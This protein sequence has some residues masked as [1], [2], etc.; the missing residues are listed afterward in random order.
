[1]ATIKELFAKEKRD[2][3]SIRR[4]LKNMGLNE[5]L[6]DVS[7]KDHALRIAKGEVFGY[8]KGSVSILSNSIKSQVIRMT[9]S[10]DKVQIILD[11]PVRPSLGFIQT[12]KKIKL[13][14][15]TD[16]HW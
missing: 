1:M 8:T 2:P 9:E 5:G 13:W 3:L 14:L 10:K 15:S 16:L 12:L 7:I 4:W 11:K 6:I